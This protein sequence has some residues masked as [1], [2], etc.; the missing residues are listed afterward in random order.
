MI[1]TPGNTD[2]APDVIIL[3]ILTD[4]Y[5]ANAILLPS[6]DMLSNL[7]ASHAPALL[8]HLLSGR[9]ASSPMWAHWRG[10]YGLTEAEQE[11]VWN[12]TDAAHT[13]HAEHAEPEELAGGQGVG[14]GKVEDQKRDE[15]QEQDKDEDK[16]KQRYTLK[17]RTYE[18]EVRRVEAV[19]GETLLS[20]A[21]RH[22]LPAMEGTCGGNLGTSFC[23]GL[24][25]GFVAVCRVLRS[26]AFGSRRSATVH[27]DPLFI[28]L[29]QIQLSPSLARP[30][31]L[32][33]L[34]R[35]HSITR[36]SL[37]PI[38]SLALVRLPIPS[39]PRCRASPNRRLIPE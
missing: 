25:F 19:R 14:Q 29:Q 22:R 24:I 33:T 2:T 30:Q 39:V 1:N 27:L 28:L 9:P 17:F 36:P 10:R 5:A 7:D 12:G 16:E 23:S 32:A 31:L 15:G 35:R 34:P 20:V 6:L 37:R 11:G 26:C 18:G 13:E 21:K 38:P 3:A 8:T 4:R